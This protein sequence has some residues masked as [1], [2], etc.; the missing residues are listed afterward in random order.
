MGMVI[1]QRFT[2][3]KFLEPCLAHSQYLVFSIRIY[4]E[5]IVPA[6]WFGSLGDKGILQSAVLV[7]YLVTSVCK[8]L[9]A[10]RM[11]T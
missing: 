11:F 2:F 10:L 4:L 5:P 1:V 3:V 9:S 7:S 8:C 6:W